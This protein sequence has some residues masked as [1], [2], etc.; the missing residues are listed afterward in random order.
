MSVKKVSVER[1]NL[2]FNGRFGLVDS[3]IVCFLDVDETM[4]ST[5]SL[6]YLLILFKF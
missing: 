1:N 2:V 5:L 4:M 3:D 6:S